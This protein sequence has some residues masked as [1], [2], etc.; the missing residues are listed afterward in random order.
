MKQTFWKHLIIFNLR[1]DFQDFNLFFQELSHILILNLCIQG[2]I[3]DKDLGVKEDADLPF[4]RSFWTLDSA[5]LLSVLLQT[6]HEQ[7]GH[8]HWA[9]HLH[10]CLTR[11]T[12]L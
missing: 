6:H 2:D 3:S 4:P 9:A 8:F 10:T 11:N 5:T 12:P 1:R 7:L